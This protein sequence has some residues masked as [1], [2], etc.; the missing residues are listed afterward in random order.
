[1]L[2]VVS[3]RE[4]TLLCR[5]N[6]SMHDEPRDLR[7]RWLLLILNGVASVA[8][9]IAAIEISVAF[10]RLVLGSYLAADAAL[11][12]ALA[13]FAAAT[14]SR[15]R[16]LF[17]ADGLLSLA[18]APGSPAVVVVV[19]AWA[20]GTGVLE[21]LAAILVPQYPL[22]PWGIALVGL[23]S[24]CFG[25]VLFDWVDLAIVGVLYVFGVYAVLTAL[26]LTLFGFLLLRDVRAR[27]H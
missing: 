17:A 3:G 8:V 19:A 4:R 15:S 14:P 20:I 12:L 9:G 21:V 23:I 22:L 26:L 10:G 6:G 1:V 25:L 16:A 27:R 11:A 18:W 7:R 2:F 13:A 5:K 24:C